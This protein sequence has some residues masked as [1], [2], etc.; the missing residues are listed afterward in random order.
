MYKLILSNKCKKC[1]L[2][3]DIKIKNGKNI[4]NNNIST[5]N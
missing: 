4:I 3:K 5:K 2:R 1:T